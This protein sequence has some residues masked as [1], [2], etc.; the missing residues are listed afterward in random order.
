V[1]LT[2][3]P[4]IYVGSTPATAVYVGSTLVWSPPSSAWESW[5]GT[6]GAVPPVERWETAA[7]SLGTVDQTGDGHLRILS[8]PTGGGTSADGA[9][10][11]SLDALTGE[12]VTTVTW[13]MTGGVDAN[14][15]TISWCVQDAGTLEPYTGF[16]TDGYILLFDNAGDQLWLVRTIGGGASFIGYSTRAGAGLDPLV[17][18]AIWNVA[19]DADGT[20]ARAWLWNDGDTRPGSPTLSAADT[21]YA[22]GKLRMMIPGDTFPSSEAHIGPV[23]ATPV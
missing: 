15:L 16:P 2:D 14:P 11:R 18:G 12:I 21:T 4:A 8:G 20:T 6:A 23:E 5:A 1:K 17:P 10:I 22:N 7:A 9:P 13:E 19:V 3:S